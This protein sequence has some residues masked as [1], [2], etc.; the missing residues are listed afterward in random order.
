[1]FPVAANGRYAYVSPAAEALLPYETSLSHI[2]G[3]QD[4]AQN[5]LWFRLVNDAVGR[6][7]ERLWLRAGSRAEILIGSPAPLLKVRIDFRPESPASLE[8][9]GARLVTPPGGPAGE[10]VVAFDRASARHPMWW[11]SDDYYLYRL[12]LKIPPSASSAAQV[13]F[14]IS[15]A[16]GD[17][18]F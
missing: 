9:S 13:P 17:P 11:T 18:G 4:V 16:I 5:G 1:M 3:G 2:P 6:E 15:P 12:R 7:A 8:V 10:F 14:R